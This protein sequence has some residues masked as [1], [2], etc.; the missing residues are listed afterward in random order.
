MPRNDSGYNPVTDSYNDMTA[1]RLKRVTLPDKIKCNRCHR[2]KAPGNYSNKQLAPLRYNIAKSGRNGS[3]SSHQLTC[4]MCTG[5]QVTELHCYMCGK[6]K[7]LEAFAK[8]QRRRPDHAKCWDCMNEQLALEPEGDDVVDDCIDDDDVDGEDDFYGYNSYPG[9]SNSAASDAGTGMETLSID[10][11][12][13][14]TGSTT[15]YGTGQ[16]SGSGS[17]LEFSSYPGSPHGGGVKVPSSVADEDERYPAQWEG[18]QVGRRRVPG[19]SNLPASSQDSTAGASSTLR[20]TPG[21]SFLGT[22]FDPTRKWAKI[23]AH[24]P[25]DEYPKQVEE[26]DDDED[27]DWKTQTQGSDDEEGDS[28]DDDD[29]DGHYPH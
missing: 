22:T 21:G 19:S 20:S 5:A 13:S 12:T 14:E 10:D 16:L 25:K 4:R 27:E 9:M 8:Q 23:P 1:E 24:K 2:N 7:G 26:D 18:V 6:D 15:S 11:K 3:I 28:D 17:L 29:D